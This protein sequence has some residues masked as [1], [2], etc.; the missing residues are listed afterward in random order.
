MLLLVVGEYAY[1]F[2]SFWDTWYAV[3][4]R[5]PGGRVRRGAPAMGNHSDVGLTIGARSRG[6]MTRALSLSPKLIQVTNGSN[7]S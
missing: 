7:S 6:C 4:V 2:V 1:H 5:E 3:D